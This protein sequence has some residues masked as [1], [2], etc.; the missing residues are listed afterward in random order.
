MKRYLLTFIFLIATS[1]VAQNLFAE[2]FSATNSDGVT[3]YYNTLTETTCEVG[4]GNYSGSVNIPSTVK[5]N[6][7]TYTVTEIGRY[8]F[9]FCNNLTSVTI[10]NTVKYIRYGAF[11]ECSSLTSLKIPDSVIGIDEFAF[12]DCY[13]LAQLTLGKNL[14]TIGEQAFDNCGISSLT[15]PNSVKTIKGNAFGHCEKLTSVTIPKGVNTITSNPFSDCTNLGSIVVESGNTIYNSANNCNAIIETSTTTL[16]SGC[17]N[18]KIPNNITAINHH[19]FSG[20][21][22]LTEVTIPSSV[23]SI[24]GWAFLNCDNL[25]SIKIPKNVS[26]IGDMAFSNCDNLSSIVVESGNTHYNSVNNC[27]AIIET[28]T[29]TLIV[30]CWLTVIP[31]TVK[32]I[33]KSAFEGCYGLRSVTIPKS[34]T[35]IGDYAFR[36]CND[37]ESIVVESGNTKYNSANNCNAIIESSTNT[38]IVGCMN[39]VIPNTVKKIG[40]YAF[41]RCFYLEDLKIP[42]SVTSIG[43]YAFYH[44]YGLKELNIPK[45]V[46]SISDYAISYCTRLEKIVS[47]V[48]NVFDARQLAFWGNSQA[49]LYVPEGLVSKYQSADGWKQISTIKAFPKSGDTNEDGNINISDVVTLVNRIL[50]DSKAYYFYDTNDDGIVN[51]SDVVKLV[52]MILG[53]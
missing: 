10:P 41:Y 36:G 47:Y 30:G 7:I 20:C 11:Y 23:T 16:I 49:T 19:A 29:N 53:N 32:A 44:C 1:F 17:K 6:N 51:I 21:Y 34:V 2:S 48:T 31:N 4:R 42:N 27:N 45:S 28:S 5:N 18:T 26:S 12:S 38:L 39:T 35:S 52:N 43:N 8:A 3:I 9:M 13:Y 40:D 37:L 33:G 46:T 22:S 25:Y 15:L 24:G 50:G 14:E